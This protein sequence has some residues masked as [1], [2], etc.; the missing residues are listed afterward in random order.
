MT[1]VVEEK[2][3]PPRSKERFE[4]GGSTETK[5]HDAAWQIKPTS[6]RGKLRAITNFSKVYD[7]VDRQTVPM[8]RRNGT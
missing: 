4:N 7:R 6:R 5:N 2:Q 3:L 1:K 8:L